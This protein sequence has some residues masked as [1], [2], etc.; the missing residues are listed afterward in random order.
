MPGRLKRVFPVDG[1]RRCSSGSPVSMPAMSADPGSPVLSSL[2]GQ[3]VWVYG[4]GM[5]T[6]GTMCAYRARHILFTPT[7]S[8]EVRMVLRHLV[9]VSQPPDCGAMRP[10]THDLGIE[11]WLQVDPAVWANAWGVGDSI[12]RPACL[13][14]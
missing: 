10:P 14:H 5:W 3:Q 12:P 4:G 7:G 11:W 1:A 6:E 13:W 8:Q 2:G 9:S